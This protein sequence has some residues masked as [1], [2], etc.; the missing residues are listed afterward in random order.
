MKKAVLAVLTLVF[1]SSIAFASTYEIQFLVSKYVFGPN[2]NVSITGY[3]INITSNST[4]N[5][6]SFVNNAGV[7]V[8]VLNSSNV[9][10]SNYT[11]TSNENGTFF[12]RSSF[13]PSA[14]VILAPNLT[15]VYQITANATIENTTWSTKSNIVVVNTRI[16]DILFQLPKVNFYSSESMPITVK[17]VQRV[18]DS[19]VSVNNVSVN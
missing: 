13:N 19:F 6:T 11:F 16:D 18:G 4:L 7:A 2:E 1:L 9:S 8:A 15:G 10:Q 17:A 5:V 12:S 3:V 14:T